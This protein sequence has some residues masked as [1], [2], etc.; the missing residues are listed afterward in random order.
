[1]LEDKNDKQVRMSTGGALK[2]KEMPRDEKGEYVCT[3]SDVVS[4]R[5]LSNEREK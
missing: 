5:K 2:K 4:T 1:M 3:Y